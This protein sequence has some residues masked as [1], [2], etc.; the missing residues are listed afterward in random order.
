MGQ[1]SVAVC[2]I[3]GSLP[4]ACIRDRGSQRGGEREE[5]GGEGRKGEAETENRENRGGRERE[6][7][8]VFC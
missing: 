8:F 2:L 3:K 1:V 7:G 5:G 4:H 6:I